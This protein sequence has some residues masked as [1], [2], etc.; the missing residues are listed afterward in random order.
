MTRLKAL[1]HTKRGVDLV[2][3]PNTLI[4]LVANYMYAPLSSSGRNKNILNL[5]STSRPKEPPGYGVARTQSYLTAMPQT[6]KA[7]TLAKLE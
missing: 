3:L 7:S 4:V 5:A 1:G 6:S 2:W